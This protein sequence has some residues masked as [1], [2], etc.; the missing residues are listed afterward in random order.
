MNRSDLSSLQTLQRCPAPAKLNLFLHVT[1]QRSDG[2][3]LL[4]TVFCLLDWNDYLDFTLRTDGAV[5]RQTDVPEVP[6]QDDLT[7]RAA[8]L[9]QQT[10][11][12][13]LGVDIAIDKNLPMGAGLGGGSSNAATTLIALNRLW[14]LGLS[15]ETLQILG[16]RLGADV[17]FFVYGRSAFAEG[18]GDVF[19]PLELK[20]KHYVVVFP[21]VHIPT[22]RIFSSGELTRDSVPITISDFAV[23]TTRND[24]QK[25]ACKYY[26]EVAQAIDWL[27]QYAP[28]ARMTGSGACVFAEVVTRQEGQ[29]I[30]AQCPTQWKAW[31]TQ[32]I[33]QH[34][35]YDWTAA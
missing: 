25:V 13:N 27:K 24:L 30:V 22:A 34:E 21:G 4:Q 8:R 28:T 17:P 7:V 6:E 23:S 32:S 12:C 29:Q 18:V 19:Q 5:I 26:P 1:G 15:R 31:Y 9:L 35:L 14:Q 11:G 3:H 16:R 20:K 2:Y 10:T 33:Q